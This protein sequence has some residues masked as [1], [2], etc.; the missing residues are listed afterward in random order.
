MWCC[1]QIPSW[2]SAAIAT[3]G[4]Q[5]EAAGAAGGDPSARACSPPASS[6]PGGP[7]GPIWI[8]W[9]RRLRAGASRRT[10]R[11]AKEFGEALAALRRRRYEA[12]A[13]GEPVQAPPVKLCH[14][15]VGIP[16]TVFRV[17]PWSKLSDQPGTKEPEPPIRP[18]LCPCGAELLFVTEPVGAA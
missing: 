9:T 17:M 10:P 3:I 18:S 2:S 15:L 8:T 5:S 14:K 6:G 12:R 11:E 4:R 7:A 16:E 13:K 1:R